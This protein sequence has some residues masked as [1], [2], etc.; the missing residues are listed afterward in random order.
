MDATWSY[1]VNKPG[2]GK[3]T[4]TLD[5]RIPFDSVI[6]TRQEGINTWL[7]ASAS[8]LFIDRSA[9]RN[10]AVFEMRQGYKSKDSKRQNA[11]MANAA[12]AYAYQYLP[13]VLLLSNQ[14]DA[15][16]ALRYQRARWLIL[17][18]TTIGTPLDS[19]YAFFRDV[20]G[21]DLA[22][23]FSHNSPTLKSEITSVMEKLLGTE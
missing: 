23:F 5:G 15:D 11:D 8:A 12:N 14:I 3:Q 9:I 18:G 17:R 19:T 16:V 2:G 1:S 4:L 13:V 22:G 6:P 10:G 20:I 21:Y 7:D